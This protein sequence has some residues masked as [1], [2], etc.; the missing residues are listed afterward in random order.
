MMLNFTRPADSCNLGIIEKLTRSCIFQNCTRNHTITYTR[1]II[2]QSVSFPCFNSQPVYAKDRES[3]TT[4]EI[5][6][7]L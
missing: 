6:C 5:T 4:T 2:S 1:R 7:L 3:V